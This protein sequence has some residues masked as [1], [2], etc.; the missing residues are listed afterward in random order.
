[1]RCEKLR[2]RQV[3]QNLIDNAIKYM[4]QDGP[5]EIRIS[6]GTAD[7][8][9]VFSVAD[10]GMGIAPEDVPSL[11]HVFRRAKN[12]TTMK[13]PGKGVGLASVKSIIE[14]YNGRLWVQSTPGQGTTFHFALPQSHFPSGADAL[15]GPSSGTDA[16]NPQNPESQKTIAEL[17]THSEVSV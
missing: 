14:N 7:G 17:P 6:V 10:T 5:K 12:A 16:P 11:F 4:R 3:F 13:V 2:A 9:T 1:M 15:V 8:E